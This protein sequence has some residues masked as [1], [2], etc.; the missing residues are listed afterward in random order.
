MEQDKIINQELRAIEPDVY[1]E[2]VR[3]R[4]ARFD[5]LFVYAVRSTRVY[6]KPSCPSR[7]PRREQV[8][9]FNACE[10]AEA[11]GFR[12]CKRC[13]PREPSPPDPSV[14]LVLRAC[15]L[16]EAREGEPAPLE[17]LGR[18]LGA[19][20]HHLQRTF[21]KVTG[22]TPRQYA[23]ALRLRQFK[24]KV[25][26]GRGVTEAL[27]ESGY[28]SSSRLYERVS[29]RL[30]MTPAGYRRGGKGMSISY[31]TVGC[32]MGRL[33]VAATERGVCSIQFGDSD[34][35]LEAALAAEYPA[36]ELGR[37]PSR[38]DDF[39]GALLR[40]LGGRSSQLELPLDVRA[41]AFQSRVWEELRRIPY[42][43]TRSY[44]EVAR[45]LGR[46]TA[47]RAVA[48]AC[49]TNPVALVN[50]CHRVVRGDGSLSGYRW[51]VGRK[52]ALL[53]REREGARESADESADANPLLSPRG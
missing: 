36:A 45:S 22:I 52:R 4:D 10:E 50:P 51:G 7:R 32:D 42:G 30:G 19:S 16:I 41:T 26:E 9:F 21:K 53:A 24:T 1:W 17:E 27:Y 6:C 34:A 5:G 43:E 29:E 49:A 31:T 46:P 48:R 8:S 11:G 13:L 14:E 47:T 44:A 35:E 3:A 28:G 20:P 2:A 40:H 25:R 15:A 23:A 12:A 37:D 18:E 33:L 38:L 39:V